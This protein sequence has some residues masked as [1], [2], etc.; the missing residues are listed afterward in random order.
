MIIATI[1]ARSAEK[2]MH[3]NASFWVFVVALWVGLVFSVINI[4]LKIDL[5]MGLWDKQ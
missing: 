3:E 4:M 5:F 2:A 1:A